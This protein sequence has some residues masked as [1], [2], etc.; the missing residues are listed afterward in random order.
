MGRFI[1]TFPVIIHF[2][3]IKFD[4]INLDNNIFDFIE[5]NLEKKCIVCSKISGYFYICLVCG[6]KVCVFNNCNKFTNHTLK[7]TGKY[8]IFIDI[9]NT[10]ISIYQT[11]GK[12]KVISSLY[13]NEE[14]VGPEKRKIGREFV[15]N[16]EKAKLIFR[17]FVCYDF[18]F[19]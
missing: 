13:N 15:L 18:H 17:N 11:N 12:R 7:C 9:H 19:N 8:C 5:T 1:T 2:S 4:F 10:K 6:N 16:K 3:P 14:G